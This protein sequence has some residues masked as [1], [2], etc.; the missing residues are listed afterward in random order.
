VGF[1]TSI[2]LCHG[3]LWVSGL[4]LQ[5]KCRFDS[6]RDTHRSDLD[7]SSGA[8]GLNAGGGNPPVGSRGKKGEDKGQYRKRKKR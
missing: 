7:I 4:R 2:K 5:G 3:N 1:F 8:D 6:G